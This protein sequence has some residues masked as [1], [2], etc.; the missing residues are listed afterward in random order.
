[1]NG[2]ATALEEIKKLASEAGA[3]AS[4]R[5]RTV[6]APRLT[7]L[8]EASAIVAIRAATG[9]DVTTATTAI[10]ASLAN[11]AREERALILQDGRELALRAVVSTLLRLGSVAA[12][13]A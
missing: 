6:T 9:E 12:A 5:Y 4:D 8:L 13:G 11:I 7:A 1:V 10:E 3:K 2:V